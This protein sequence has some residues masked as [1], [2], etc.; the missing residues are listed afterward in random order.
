M[1]PQ[2]WQVWSLLPFVTEADMRDSTNLALVS[3]A[4]T[5]WMLDMSR[6]FRTGTPTLWLKRAPKPYKTYFL[7][8][9][10]SNMR[11]E[12]HRAK[13]CNILSQILSKQLAQKAIILRTFG[14]R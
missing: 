6:D 2:Y 1:G 10:P 8:Q 9:T 3:F 12:S 5:I 13:T 11:P 14:S 4:R 7:G